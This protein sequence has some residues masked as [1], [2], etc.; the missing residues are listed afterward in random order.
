MA[1]L[2][3]T[4]C[5]L[6]PVLLQALRQCAGGGKLH[7]EIADH[8][9]D[10]IEAGLEGKLPMSWPEPIGGRVTWRNRAEPEDIAVLYLA[11]G[12]KGLLKEKAYV[13][14]LTRLFGVTEKN[15]EYWQKYRAA[16]ITTASN[17]YISAF[18][19]GQTIGA[20]SAETFAQALEGD[21]VFPKE[22]PHAK[23][24]LRK[25]ADEYRAR[26]G[27]PPLEP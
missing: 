15:I 5:Q 8:L 18:C 4:D 20:P 2:R 7:P 6:M 14:T 16:D 3:E 11:A 12:R 9:A 10:M 24:V 25:A 22:L 17:G 23:G 21:P 1:E 13:K 19:Y 26:R 27:L